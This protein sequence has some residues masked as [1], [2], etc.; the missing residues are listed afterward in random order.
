V[1]AGIS[2]HAN[3]SGPNPWYVKG[4]ACLSCFFFDICVPFEKTFGEER[5]VELPF[6][7]P[8]P[9]LIAAVA[10][11]RNWSGSLPFGVTQVV[12]LAA[13][14]SADSFLNPAGALTLR[15]TVLPLNRTL[16]KFGATAPVGPNRYDLTS[17]VLGTDTVGFDTYTD[18]FAAAEF[19]D[20]SDDEKLSRPSFERMDAGLIVSG[21]AVD[22]GPAIGT[23]VSYETVLVDDRF[24]SR[25]GPRYFLGLDVQLAT[26][27][28]GAAAR[29]ILKQSG[30]AKFA[31][32]AT[33]PVR[34]SLKEDRFVVISTDDLGVRDD[35]SSPANKGD[36]MRALAD[37]LVANPGERGRLQ[38]A[39]LD[40]IEVPV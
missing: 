32:E 16:T 3:L 27:F 8:Q 12:S 29:S 25:N 20:M 15:Q 2:L 1:L 6:T 38:V 40:E 21:G 14:Q 9:L 5:Q 39:P 30:F 11:A 24:N 17:V 35:I 7:D 22:H 31:P 26:S 28:Q 13:G 18:F 23:A 4:N 37:Y 34:V 36:A 10:D 33:A 19:E